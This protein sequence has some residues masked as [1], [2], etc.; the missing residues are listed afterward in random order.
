MWIVGGQ[1][2]GKVKCDKEGQRIKLNGLF[3]LGTK[4]LNGLPPNPKHIKKGYEGSG[5]PKYN[6][7]MLNSL[8]PETVSRCSR[9]S[10]ASGRFI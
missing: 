7:L 4:K 5:Q 8:R 3:F 2:K 9:C 6:I 1:V 10:K